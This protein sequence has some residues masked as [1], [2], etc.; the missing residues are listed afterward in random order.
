M[1]GFRLETLSIASSTIM[2]LLSTS[3]ASVESVL[4]NRQLSEVR[5][6]RGHTPVPTG[7]NAV[8]QFSSS[9]PL[10]SSISSV[11]ESSPKSTSSSASSGNSAVDSAIA[12]DREAL[13]RQV[14]KLR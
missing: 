6:A 1:F 14:E 10:R 13:A 5:E 4:P 11:S 9:S 8:Q 7:S 2:F 3:R 12:A